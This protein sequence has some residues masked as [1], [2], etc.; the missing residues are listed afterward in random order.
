MHITI[1]VSQMAYQ[2]TGVGR[3]TFELCQALLLV[4]SE[5]KLTFWAGSLRKQ[6]YFKELSKHTPWSAAKWINSPISPKLAGLV[7]NHIPLKLDK[8]FDSPD[9]LHTSDWSEPNSVCPRVTTVHDLVFAKYP[10]TLDSLILKTQ[11][12]RIK[13]LQN[14]NTF[15]ITD[16]MST[17]NDLVEMYHFDK[18]RIKVVYPG[19]NTFY[20]PQGMQEIERVKTK[21]KLPDQFVL[22][23]GTQEP[24]KNLKRLIQATQLAK[25]PLV[26]AGKYGWGETVNSPAH[27]Q[28]LGFVDEADLPGLYS[29]ASV[30]ALVSLYEGFGFPALEAMSCGTALVVSNTS[31]LPELVEAAGILVDPIDPESIANGIKL[32][33]TKQSELRD[34]GLLQ[35]TKFSWENTAKEVISIYEQIAQNRDRH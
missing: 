23:L 28:V 3:Y 4:R 24:R 25:I 29:S 22:T 12:K 1:D 10:E 2:G 31:S 32:A 6:A 33:L 14:N 11:K 30:F 21:Y 13:K 7:F 17:K 16:S 18:V 27:V 19:I 35:A 9:L 15:I 8:I 20:K 5:H 26:I 34:K